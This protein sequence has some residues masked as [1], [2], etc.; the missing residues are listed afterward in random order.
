MLTRNLLIPVAVVAA[1]FVGSS[2]ARADEA[3][4]KQGKKVFN[5]CKICHEIAKEKNKLGP[6]LVGI[7]GRKAGSVE[8][9]KYSKA[10]KDSKVVWD[11]TSIDAYVTKPK[12]FIPGNKMAFAG[13]KSEKQR[14]AL[15]EYIKSAAKK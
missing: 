1:V 3:L 13:I 14:K 7:M 4:A 5:K 6:H 11:E 15:L 8:G 12:K 10:M 9:F 2:A